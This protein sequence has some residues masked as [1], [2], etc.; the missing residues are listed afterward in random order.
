[1]Q[2]EIYQGEKITVSSSTLH[3]E[4]QIQKG[5]RY[6][7]KL[8]KNNDLLI[9][10]NLATIFFSNSIN[11]RYQNLPQEITEASRRGLFK[12]V[13]WFGFNEMV[14]QL[15]PFRKAYYYIFLGGQK[16]ANVYFS[17]KITLGYRQYTMETVSEDET[18]NINIIVA[19]LLRLIPV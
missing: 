6:H 17:K 16:V 11:I 8:L 12:F 7:V 10:W 9:E 14:V 4:G 1:M 18:I 5:S 19:F 2:F 13:V 3:L 15:R